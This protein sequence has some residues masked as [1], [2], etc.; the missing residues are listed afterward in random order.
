MMI[1]GVAVKFNNGLEVRVPKPGRHADCFRRAIDRY[2][3]SPVD[4]IGSHGQGFYDDQGRYLT[5]QEAM[6]HVKAVGQKLLP[7]PRDGHINTSDVLT[8]ED[9]WYCENYGNSGTKK[10]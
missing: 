9:L 1:L 8:S 2:N 5:R 4:C 3:V 6:D 7:D 10:C